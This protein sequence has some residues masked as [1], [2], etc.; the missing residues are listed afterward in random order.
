[1]ELLKIAPARANATLSGLT[2]IARAGC[3][4]LDIPQRAILD[5]LQKLVLAPDISVDSLSD[6]QPEDLRQLITDPAEVRQLIRL[7]VI[8][9]L[10]D[11]PPNL[12]QVS[13]IMR[14]ADALDVQ[15]PAVKV[16]EH[17]AKNQ[18]WRFRMA[19]FRHSHVRNYFRNTY[20]ITGTVWQFIKAI[21]V[22]RGVTEDPKLS[23]RFRSL[24]HLP[25]ETLG[26]QFF[27]HC[28]QERLPFPGER[29]GFPVGA[30]YHDFTHLLSGYDTTPEGEIKAA[31]FQAG[32]TQDD[33]DFFTSLF[34][35]L[36]HT[37]GINVAPFPMPVLLG[38]IGQGNLA[39]EM[40]HAMQRGSKMKVDLGV[41]WDYWQ[42]VEQPID[43]VRAKLGVP[44][45]D[46]ALFE[47]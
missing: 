40:F 30:V 6:I 23:A 35:I 47:A 36:I 5:A 8:V 37:A 41:E 16:I 24:E 10:A 15:E 12:A 7:M 34:A 1:M 21:L 27:D 46:V 45:V 14:F 13:L 22:F 25:E 39:L 3:N 29:G 17:L 2:M 32:Y 26:H 19:F 18:R 38:R 4:G 9:S 11:G 33:D 31:A 28:V 20:R 44:P 43:V 42:Y